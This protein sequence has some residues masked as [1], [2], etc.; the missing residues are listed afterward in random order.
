MSCC[1]EAFAFKVKF[2]VCPTNAK[3]VVCT[4]IAKDGVVCKETAKFV[5]SK[6]G[7]SEYES[8]H[9]KGWEYYCETVSMKTTN[10]VASYGSSNMKEMFE[11]V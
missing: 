7:L 1:G 3:F 5:A 11:M 10:G 8:A 4:N 2:T 6:A 9:S